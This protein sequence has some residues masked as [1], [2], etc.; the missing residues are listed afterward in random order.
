VDAGAF[1]LRKWYL[2]CV[3]DGGDA[4]ILYCADLR[5]RE[6][7]TS[8]SSILMAGERPARSSASMASFRLSCAKG[9]IAVE[10]PRLKI[11]GQWET[12]AAA[13]ERAVYEDASGAVVW[14]CLQPGS[15]VHVRVREREFSGRGYAECL[16]VT[17][18]PW[19]LPLNQ[20]RWGRF[21]SQDESLAWVDW[22]G[23]YSTSFAVHNSMECETVS[24]SDSEVVVRD[25]TLRMDD[26]LPLRAGRAENTILPGAPILGKLLPRSLF[27]IEEHKWRS[28]GTLKTED[29]VSVGWVIH[30]VVHWRV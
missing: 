25:A 1:S 5:W 29:R 30:E 14:N 3:T 7:H 28:R 12:N 13:F 26:S 19:Q 22:Q 16:T 23:P 20:L 8:Y 18:P 9:Q 27:N 24:V 10:H 2:D 15:A 11:S 6:L 17:L 21:V 4:V